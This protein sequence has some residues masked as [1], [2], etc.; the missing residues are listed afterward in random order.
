MRVQ[1]DSR[2][3][4]LIVGGSTAK[5]RTS[6]DSDVDILLVATNEE[7]AADAPPLPDW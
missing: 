6:D 1:Y 7:Y 3:P 5:G 2:Y 4:A